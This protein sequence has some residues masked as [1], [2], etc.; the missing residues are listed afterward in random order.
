VTTVLRYLDRGVLTLTFNRPDRNNA[1]CPELEEEFFAALGDAAEDRAVKVIVV[2]GAGRS[3]C[4][5]VDIELLSASA[6]G[7]RELQGPRLPV[8]FAELVPKPV[9]AAVNG[10]CA[11]MGLVQACAAD[12]RFAASGAKFTTAFARRGLPAENAI[13]W[14]LP[15]IV[16]TGTAMD[17]LLSSRVITAEEARE[18]GMV[19][20]VFESSELMAR[21]IEYARDMAENCSPNSMA[22]IKRQ[23]LAD[24]D[25]GAEESR[26]HAVA[27][28]R[29]MAAAEDFAEGVA[30]YRDKRPPQFQGLS[31]VIDAE[32]DRE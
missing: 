30:S 32:T 19:N 20:R 11:G 26:L 27:A 9:I 31:S 18:L 2:T 14:M 3:F 22:E 15:R 21:T 29:E 4:P 13:S 1:W 17:L 7:E 10:A 5:G 24:W 23:V 16:G 12:I 28:L 25:R 8:T 6:K